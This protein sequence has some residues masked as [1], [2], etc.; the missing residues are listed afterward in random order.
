MGKRFVRANEADA[1]AIALHLQ[2]QK[3]ENMPLISVWFTKSGK[4]IAIGDKKEKTRC[5]EFS[6]DYVLS[7][8][9]D[10]AISIGGTWEN[11]VTCLKR[12]A[13]PKLPQTEIDEAV[14]GFLSGEES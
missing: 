14:R 2:L 1:R 3:I 10:K 12:P 4:T 6:V 13:K 5:R 7:F 11:L 9:V 8:D